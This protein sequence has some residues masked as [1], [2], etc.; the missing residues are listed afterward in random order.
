VHDDPLEIDELVLHVAKSDEF[1]DEQLRRLLDARFASDLEIHPN[2]I[3]FHSAEDLRTMQ[4][5]GTQLKEQRV[6]DHR[7]KSAVDSKSASPHNGAAANV[8]HKL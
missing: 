2:R 7:P 5:V 4:G 8:P 3:E 1:N 6:V